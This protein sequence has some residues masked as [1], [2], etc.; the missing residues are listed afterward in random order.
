MGAAKTPRDRLRSQKKPFRTRE[1]ICLDNEVADEFD[2]VKV[3]RDDLLS[4]VDSLRFLDRPVDAE[5]Q[6]ALDDAEAR[7]VEAKEALDAVT[8]TF[9]FRSI[10]RNAFDKLLTEHPPTDAQIAEAKEQGVGRPDFNRDSLP[11]VLCAESCV[12]HDFDVDWWKATFEDESWNAAELQRL[13]N[14]AV[15]AQMG[16]RVV[17]MG[18]GSAAK[19]S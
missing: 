16:V 11:P 3:E 9:E 8:E 1:Q 17:E 7:Y 15:V 5:T 4:K 13:S 19:R 14:A 2:A 12:S 10:G 6:R 18:K